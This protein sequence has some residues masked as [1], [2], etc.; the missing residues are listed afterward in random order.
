MSTACVS[1]HRVT[2]VAMKA[3][4]TGNTSWLTITAIDATGGSVEVTL[5]TSTPEA[6]IAQLVG[7]DVPVRDFDRERAYVPAWPETVEG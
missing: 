1:F 7:K 6:L 5:Y 2:E 4:R 3:T